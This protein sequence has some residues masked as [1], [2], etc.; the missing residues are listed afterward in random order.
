[1][2]TNTFGQLCIVIYRNSPAVHRPGKLI[3][4]K[5]VKKLKLKITYWRQLIGYLTL[6]G[7]SEGK[8]LSRIDE[9]GIYFSRYGEIWTYPVSKI[10]NSSNFNKFKEWFYEEVIKENN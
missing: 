3:D 6:I 2:Y 9:I 4:I 1:M 8:D 10:Y 5:T 7:L